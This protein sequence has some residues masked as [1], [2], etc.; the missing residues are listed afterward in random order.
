MLVNRASFRSSRER[1]LSG[2]ACMLAVDPG[3][4]N[5]GCLGSRLTCSGKALILHRAAIKFERRLTAATWVCV[6]TIDRCYVGLCS[7]VDTLP[8]P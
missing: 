2:R 3:C 8:L 7:I 6:A 4:W 1:S 5:C